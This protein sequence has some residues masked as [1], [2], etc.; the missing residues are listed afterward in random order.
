MRYYSDTSTLFIR[1]AFRAASTGI[2]GGIRSVSTLLNH[3]LSPSID[4]E[5]AEKDLDT[6]IAA[7]GLEKNYFGLTTAVPVHQ[8][9]VFQF[10]FITVFIT[11]GI[12]REPPATGGSINIIIVSSQGME[13]AALLETIMVAAEAKAEALQ[14][15]DLPLSGTPSDAIITACGEEGK[16]R[17][18]SAGRSTEAGG[19]A[20]EA[21]LYGLPEAIRR[22]DAAIGGDRPAF[23]IFSRFKGEH[24]IEWTMKDCPYYPCHFEGQSC[25]Y[26]YCPFYPCHDE[27]L[28]Q[29]A[30]SATGGRVWNCARCRLPHEPEVAAYFRK[31]PGASR[32]ELMTRLKQLKN[33]L[34]I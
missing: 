22:H 12:R 6:I 8:T 27:T 2:S 9:C 1:G 21:V 34:S 4:A 29:W 19:R 16:I 33:N 10:D 18:R 31:F 32:Q 26:C 15:M 30:A 13:D 5:V 25:E 24:W 11:A 3:T 20:R 28:G 7:A 23:F 14:G 17:H